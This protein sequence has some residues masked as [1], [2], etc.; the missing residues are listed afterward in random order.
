MVYIHHI[1]LGS[2]HFGLVWTIL[3]TILLNGLNELV[4]SIV[5]PMASSHSRCILFLFLIIKQKY[6]WLNKW[7][8]V[9]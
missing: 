9:L 1:L 3:T 6:G 7:L 5:R 8:H 2:I 4:H